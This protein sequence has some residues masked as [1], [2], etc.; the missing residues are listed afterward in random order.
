VILG[1]GAV[2]L[3]L[4]LVLWLASVAG[5]DAARSIA[6]VGGLAVALLVVAIAIGRFEG[7]AA[8]LALLGGCYAA[9]L[10]I[11][12]PPLDA[13]SALVGAGLLA[14][15]ELAHLSLSRRSA[16]T[17]EAGAVTRR[18][19]W[20]ALLA[21]CAIALGGAVLAVVDLLRTGGIAIELMGVAAAITAVGLL[22]LA[23]RDAARAEG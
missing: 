12:D 14:T 16:V 22:A 1:A 21:L 4:G 8:S 11:D 23:A 13:R 2:G 7:V 20:V 6:Y 10:V 3:A 15:G 17:D 5:S 19:A 9:I 18:V